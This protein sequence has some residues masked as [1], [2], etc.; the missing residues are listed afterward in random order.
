MTKAVNE[1]GLEWSPPEEP[2]RSRLD[3]W[4]LPGRHQALRQRSTPFF[5]E[6]H[7]ELTK[8]WQAPYSSHIHSFAFAAQWWVQRKVCFWFPRAHFSARVSDR[9]DSVQNKTHAFSEREQMSFSAYHKRPALIQPVFKAVSTPCQASRGLAGHPRCVR[10]GNGYGK[11]RLYSPI[12]S[13]TTTFPP[14]A[15]YHSAQRERSSPSRRGDESAGKRS[16]I[17]RSIFFTKSTDALAYKWPSLPLYSFSPVALLPQ[18]LRRV[19]EQW[20]KHILIGPLWRNQPWMSE[21]FQLL[22]AAPWPIPLRRDLLSQANGTIW[23]PRPEYGPCMCGCS[24]GAFRPPERVLNTMAEARA[25][26]Y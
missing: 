10:V 13:K 14:C 6:V 11:M 22:K 16:K 5:P 1:L 25:P 15:R 4:F 7:D 23:H 2:S 3:E 26:I 24:T 19:R 9:C 21:L 12:R 8:S 18:V 17:F 20:H